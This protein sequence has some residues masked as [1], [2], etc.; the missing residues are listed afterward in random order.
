MLNLIQKNCETLKE[1]AVRRSYKIFLSKFLESRIAK[2]KK[3]I[4]DSSCS[5]EVSDSEN[6]IVAVLVV[7]EK[8]WTKRIINKPGY[9]LSI[10]IFFLNEKSENEKLLS[11][12]M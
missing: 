8:F 9:L 6:F 7:H 3:L 2:R 5:F 10:N 11:N 4:K 1:E 12:I